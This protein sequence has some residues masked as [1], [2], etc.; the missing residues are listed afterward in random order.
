MTIYDVSEGAGVSIATV[1]R[2][3]NG[4]N[5]H[6]SHEDIPAMAKQL[7]ELHTCHVL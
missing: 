2:M 5:N 1:S 4:S 3:L 6:C 7:K